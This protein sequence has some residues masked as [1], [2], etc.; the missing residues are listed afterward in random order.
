MAATHATAAIDRSLPDP[1]SEPTVSVARAAAI[2]SINRRTIY[3]AIARGD[4]PSV[5]IGRRVVVPTARLVALI[6]GG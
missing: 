3:D 4:I 2:L 1:V 5:R 6:N